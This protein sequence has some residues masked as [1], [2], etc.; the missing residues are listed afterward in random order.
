[1][2]NEA[3]VSAG[4]S[5]RAVRE[6]AGLTLAQAAELTGRSTGY[7][8]Q[9]ENG[10]AARV[11]VK[12]VANTIGALSAYISDPVAKAQPAISEEDAA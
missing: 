12:Y 10:K 2:Q 8:S 4:R 11:S 7:L 6:L 5:I 3:A 9:V 1:M